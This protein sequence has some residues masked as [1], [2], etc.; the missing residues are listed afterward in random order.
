MKNVPVFMK[1]CH[2][3][4]SGIAQH[5]SSGW[6]N[7]WID[8]SDLETEGIFRWGDGVLASNGWTK[9]RPGEPNNVGGVEDCVYLYRPDGAT[10]NDNACS[11]QFPALC[12]KRIW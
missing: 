7:V 10:W 9:W 2:E 1:I 8:L 4:F 12:E 11:K 3:T 5:F 6:L